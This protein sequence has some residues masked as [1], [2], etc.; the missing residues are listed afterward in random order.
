MKNMDI[1]KFQELLMIPSPSGNEENIIKKMEEYLRAYVNDVQ[2][3]SYGNLI[4]VKKES[5]RKN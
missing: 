3:D 5:A 1:E 2:I 4:A